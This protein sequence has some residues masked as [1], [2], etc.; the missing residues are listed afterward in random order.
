MTIFLPFFEGFLLGIGAA[1]PIGPI[2]ILIMNEAIRDYKNGVLIGFGAMSAD[3]LYFA[4]VFFG[5]AKIIN[6]GRFSTII[7]VFGSCF[8]LY[9]AFL[10]TKSQAQATA[11]N[12]HIKKKDTLGFYLKGFILTIFNPYTVGFWVSIAGYVSLKNLD[13]VNILFGMFFAILSWIVAMPY[14]IHKIGHKISPKTSSVLNKISAIILV[15]FAISLVFG[16][17]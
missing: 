16:M 6:D 4:L 5:F 9:M 1:V 12:T 14:F 8:L 3:I 2:N 17:L 13:F 15:F 11:D 10:M 7:A